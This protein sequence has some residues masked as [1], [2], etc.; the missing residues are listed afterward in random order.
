MEESNKPSTSPV[1]P[2]VLLLAAGVFFY[3]IYKD[4]EY[5]F[6]GYSLTEKIVAFVIC[7]VIGGVIFAIASGL[8]NAIYKAI[9]EILIVILLFSN[10][11]YIAYY[12]PKV[13]YLFDSSFADTSEKVK[14][15]ALLLL[16]LFLYNIIFVVILI[17]FA[18][19][20]KSDLLDG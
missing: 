11:L 20:A 8:I 5:L 6:L 4:P 9:I 3:F 19:I 16:I 10:A 2:I 1:F 17:P 7:C 13:R 15:V 14:Y 18:R 12:Y